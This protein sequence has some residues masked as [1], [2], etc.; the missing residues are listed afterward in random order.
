MI[1]KVSFAGLAVAFFTL[2]W[3][4]CDKNS[5][6]TSV[7]DTAIIG[8]WTGLVI[9]TGGI[10]HDTN[11]I[12]LTI[13]QTG[14]VMLRGMVKHA[15]S[16]DAMLDSAWEAGTYT[17]SGNNVTLNSDTCKTRASW[18][19]EMSSVGCGAP[20]TLPVAINNNAWTVTMNEWKNGLPVTYPMRKQ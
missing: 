20:I 3:F 4:G 2:A 1:R 12:E 14:Y 18:E 16:G 5:S 6:P 9:S 15:S 17:L 7:P 19:T 10:S 13:T 11:S 8:T